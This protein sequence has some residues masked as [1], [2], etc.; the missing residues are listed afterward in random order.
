MIP[1]QLA[2]FQRRNQGGELKNADVRN[3]KSKV[4]QETFVR[5]VR[6]LDQYGGYSNTRRTLPEYQRAIDLSCRAAGVPCE[7][8]FQY[9][10]ASMGR[11]CLEGCP[12]GI[13]GDSVAWLWCSAG[14]P[15]DVTLEFPSKQ[16]TM[17]PG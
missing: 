5:G 17:T 15:R 6:P 9:W 11:D 2:V 14:C 4:Y 12:S 10:R 7:S 16:T 1:L 8:P 3:F 13:S